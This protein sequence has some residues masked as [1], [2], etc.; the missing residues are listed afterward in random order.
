VWDKN[1]SFGIDVYR[2]DLNNWKQLG[3]SRNTT[4]QQS[5]TGFQTR[6]GVPMTENMS[7]IGRYTLNL[8]DVTLDKSLYYSDRVTPGVFEC[9]PLLASRYLCDAIGTR[10]SSILG[11]SLV[12]RSL[13]N[14]VRPTRGSTWS[15]NLDFAGLGG[16]VKYAKF[17][18]NW[19]KYWPLGGGWIFSVNTE[20]GV[21]KGFGHTDPGQDPV[22]LTDRF[23][24]GEPNMRGFDIR[25]V[26]PRIIREAYAFDSTSGTPIPV[27][28]DGTKM[29]DCTAHGGYTFT[30]NPDNIYQDA[31]GG[32]AY[33]LGKVELE[34]PLGSGAREMGL[35]PSV[36]MDVGS[37][38]HVTQPTLI[39]TGPTYFIPQKD[40]T[41]GEPLYTQINVATLVTPTGG[42]TPVCTAGTADGD[43]TVVTNPVNPNPPACLT[44]ANNAPIGQTSLGFREVFLGDTWKPRL[45]IGIGVNWNSPFGPYRI[46]F[47]K[48]LLKQKGD[49]TKAFSFN[50]GTQF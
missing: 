42:T 10:T 32:D 50:V 34:I 37:V 15:L 4:N 30:T 16:S 17:R 49:D 11:A 6:V 23:F 33:Y 1:W 44:S 18:G 29:T 26:G 12:Y 5:T 46:D 3:H 24:L 38:F 2:T 41:T 40:P 21:I 22:R 48:V 31:L 47:A 13:D 14:A 28:V 45:S 7:L 20:A 35:R 27:C 8:D 19:G 36:F 9:D 25:G 39:D 43:V